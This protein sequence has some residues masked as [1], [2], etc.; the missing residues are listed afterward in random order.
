[1]VRS[2]SIPVTEYVV[3][4]FNPKISITITT[5]EISHSPVKLMSHV[6]ADVTLISFHFIY[7]NMYRENEIT[8]VSDELSAIRESLLASEAAKDDL[9][10]LCNEYSR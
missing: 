3:V 4:H 9:V 8:E 2:T 5:C 1:V 7:Y 10:R 6:A